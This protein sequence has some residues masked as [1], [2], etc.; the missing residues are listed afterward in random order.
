MSHP[1]GE[2]AR[3]KIYASSD[4]A[5]V[6]LRGHLVRH[7][8]RQGHDIVDLGPATEAPS[9]YPDQAAQIGRAVRDDGAALGLL[10]CGSGIGVV[11]AANKIRGVRAALAWNVESAALSRS[12]NDANVLCLGARFLSEVEAEALVDIWLATGFEGGRHARRVGKIAE[13]EAA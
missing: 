1:T 6:K 10:V 2:H 13:L 5:G 3:V 8:R 11:M 4:H 9:D 7:L 12:H